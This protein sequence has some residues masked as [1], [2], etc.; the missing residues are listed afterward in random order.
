[1]TYRGKTSGAKTSSG[2][3]S[4]GKKSSEKKS[5]GKISEGW[6]NSSEASSGGV[7]IGRVHYLELRGIG[8]YSIS[9]AVNNISNTVN[10]NRVRCATEI[11]RAFNSESVFLAIT[12][13]TS[14]HYYLEINNT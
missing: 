2:K 4:S 14:I 8:R 9:N 5:G 11:S 3:K 12:V 13:Y 6:L 7:N 1:M 10:N